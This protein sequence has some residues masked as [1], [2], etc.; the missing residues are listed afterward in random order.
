MI[1]LPVQGAH[2]SSVLRLVLA[3]SQGVGVCSPFHFV[4]LI[5][6]VVG[7]CLLGLLWAAPGTALAGPSIAAVE[8]DPPIAAV[9][10]DAAIA[11]IAEDAPARPGADGPE[12]GGDDP[13][14]TSDDPEAV[15]DDRQV[16]ADDPE[17][18]SDDPQA[19]SD[20]PEAT[21][22]DPEVE[23]DD[24]E[25]TSD[26]PEATSE[27]PEAVADDPEATSG[28]PEVGADD[29][30]AVARAYL[31]GVEAMA[32]TAVADRVHPETAG[33]FRLYLEIML[34]QGVDPTELMGREEEAATASGL[35]L[36]EALE[37][38]SGVR[39]VAAYLE[40]DDSGV[41]VEAFRALERESP[42]MINAWVDRSTE[43]LGVVPEGDTLRHVVYRLEWRVSGATPD[44]EILTLASGPD[45]AWLVRKSRELDSLR[46]AITAL[47]RRPL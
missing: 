26:D 14:A 27:D 6:G 42:G 43:V 33:D 29:P 16:G 1:S 47:F 13:E 30:E 38:V 22:D 25:A 32:W 24:P 39:S 12:T 11:A 21:S 23:A 5:P 15:A 3:R 31:D 2:P 45:G 35:P 36:A 7:L 41:L 46:P 9:E 20:D 17:A 10:G 40:M 28:D 8:E 34:F 18:A 44:V 37:A 4:S 19:T